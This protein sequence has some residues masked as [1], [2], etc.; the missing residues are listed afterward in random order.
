MKPDDKHEHYSKF[1]PVWKRCR[2]AVAGQRAIQEAGDA[3]L[4]K[5]EGQ[6]D[7]A[8]DSYRS[9]ALFY[10]ATGRIVDAMVGLVFR[11]PMTWEVPEAMKEWLDDLALSDET[12]TDFAETS[13]YETLSAGRGGIWLT[14]PAQ[15]KR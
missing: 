13:L 11:K 12:S 8:Y 10:N 9:R 15:A 3:C 14:Y 1:E 7:P 6:E 2:D 5:L 4:P